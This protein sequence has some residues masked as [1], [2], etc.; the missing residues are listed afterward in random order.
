MMLT[1]D[2]NPSLARRKHL[3]HLYLGVDHSDDRFLNVKNILNLLQVQPSCYVCGQRSF[4]S[5]I[6]KYHFDE[7]IVHKPRPVH[8]LP[9][10]GHPAEAY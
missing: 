2:V 9:P 4:P 10:A 3:R 6:Y 1:I 7:L 5:R 8:R